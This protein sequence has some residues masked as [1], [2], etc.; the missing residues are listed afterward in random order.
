MPFIHPTPA[1]LKAVGRS[2]GLEMSTAE[3]REMADI[4]SPLLSAYDFL[5]AA[6]DALPVVHY[7]E[8]PYEFP[9]PEDNPYKA[10]YVRT[11]IKGAASGPLSGRTVA[12]KDVI[13]VAGVPMMNG[14]AILEGFVPDYDATVVTRLL[15]AGAEITGKAVCEHFCVSGTSCTA[16]TGT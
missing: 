10:W 7:P 12:I 9:A 8:R 2:L 16:S 11:S 6:P 3:S 13:F 4:L 5:D 14:A 1:K 15:D